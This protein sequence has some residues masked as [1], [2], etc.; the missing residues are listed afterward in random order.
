LTVLHNFWSR[1]GDGT[2][3]AERF[4]EQKPQDLF[5]WLLDEMPDLPHPAQKRPR[6]APSPLLN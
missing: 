3:A 4:F 6:V 5:E 1:R 2:T